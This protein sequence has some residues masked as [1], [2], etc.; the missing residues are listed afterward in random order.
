M[1]DITFLIFMIIFIIFLW[2]LDG[3]IH[4]VLFSMLML[5]ISGTYKTIF[6]IPAGAETFYL[7]M[8]LFITLCG[9]WK[10]IYLAQRDKQQFGRIFIFERE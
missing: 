10:A 5:F 9:F 7:I 1:T 6:M 3:I 8:I 2:A 4:L